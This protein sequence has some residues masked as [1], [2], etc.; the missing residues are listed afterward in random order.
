MSR[1][2]QTKA[3]GLTG[4]RVLILT[5]RYK[6]REGVCVGKSADSKR[7]AISPDGSNE[8]IQLVFE[9]EFGLLIDLSSNPASN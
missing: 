2:S 6:G 9:Q 3:S 8:I 5:G 4:C 1:I 7:W